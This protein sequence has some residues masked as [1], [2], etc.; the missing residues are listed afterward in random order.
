MDRVYFS[1]SSFS[2]DLSTEL[3]GCI[4]A[5]FRHAVEQTP[6]KYAIESL[7]VRPHARFLNLNNLFMKAPDFGFEP[8]KLGVMVVCRSQRASAN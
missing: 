4:Y 3:E 6:V 8:K 2:P 5:L 7:F 1:A